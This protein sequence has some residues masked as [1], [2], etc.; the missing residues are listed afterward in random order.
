MK[1]FWLFIWIT[2][3]VTDNDNHISK[4]ILLITFTSQE[5]THTCSSL[6]LVMTSVSAPPHTKT[7]L[8]QP[9]PQYMQYK[10]TQVLLCSEHPHPAADTHRAQNQSAGPDTQGCSRQPGGHLRSA[11]HPLWPHLWVWG[12]LLRKHSH[13]QISTGTDGFCY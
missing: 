9:Q 5:V 4:C 12:R 3:R 6:P 1:Y 11:T 13:R 7:Q 10:Y 8:T 2:G